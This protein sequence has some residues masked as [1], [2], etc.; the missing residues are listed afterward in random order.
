MLLSID[1]FNSYMSISLLLYFVTMAQINGRYSSSI[2]VEFPQPIDTLSLIPVDCHICWSIIDTCWLFGGIV[3]GT[4]FL[5]QVDLVY[6]TFLAHFCRS[7]IESGEMKW[8]K[9]RGC[10]FYFALMYYLLN[11]K[12]NFH[13]ITQPK[14][15]QNGDIWCLTSFLQSWIKSLLP[16][17]S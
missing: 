12:M 15:G 2:V 14:N 17:Q 9:L 11:C 3:H 8:T 4:F 10:G 5:S 6:I 13:E 16:Y 1:N 7:A